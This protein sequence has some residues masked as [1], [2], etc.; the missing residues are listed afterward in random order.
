MH[1][2][3]EDGPDRYV[4]AGNASNEM[5]MV[6]VWRVEIRRLALYGA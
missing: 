6:T 3:A 4:V 1:R 5:V 2:L